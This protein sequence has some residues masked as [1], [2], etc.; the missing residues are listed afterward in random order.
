[1]A[2]GLSI[3]HKNV[4]VLRK[5]LN[6]N[7]MLTEKELTE[8]IR[9]DKE[10]VFADLTIELAEELNIMRPFG[11]E[12]PQALFATKNVLVKALRYVGANQN[13][14]QFIFS[15]EN[16]IN[17]KGISFRGFDKFKKLIENNF[18][19]KVQ[20][21]VF[22]G[23]VKNISLF[24]DIVYTIEINEYNNKKNVQ[25]IIKDFRKSRYHIF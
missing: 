17:V 8:V 9:I 15:D 3:E 20:N 25:L 7:C 4:E 14:I 22:G 23:S 10:L 21:E 6:E 13:I 16:N 1:M 11:K 5:R 2:A 24:L 12:N 19:N 18:D